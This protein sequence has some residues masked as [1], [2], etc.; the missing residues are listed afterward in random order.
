[1]VTTIWVC[2]QVITVMVVIVTHSGMCVVVSKARIPVPARIPP[3]A[4]SQTIRFRF[5]HNNPVMIDAGIAAIP[6]MVALLPISAGV[7]K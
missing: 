7:Y 5:V 1:M 6:N 2:P 3:D 4:H